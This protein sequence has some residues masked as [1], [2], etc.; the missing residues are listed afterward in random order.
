MKLD[1]GFAR[2]ARREYLFPYIPSNPTV[3]LLYVK[4]TV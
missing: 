1:L 4:P 3:I 2:Y